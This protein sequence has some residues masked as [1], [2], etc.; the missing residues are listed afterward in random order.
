M[1]SKGIQK[2]ALSTAMAYSKVAVVGAGAAGQSLCAQLARTG[3]VN[4]FDI[5]VFDPSADH[6]Y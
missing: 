4:D 2:K 5:T 1:F 3:K 6:H